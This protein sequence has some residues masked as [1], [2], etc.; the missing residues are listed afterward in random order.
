MIVDDGFKTFAQKMVDWHAE[1][2]M[3]ADIEIQ[4]PNFWT[5]EIPSQQANVLF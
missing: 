5:K 1:G 4:H 3:P 2:L